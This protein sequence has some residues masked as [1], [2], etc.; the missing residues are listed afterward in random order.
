[1]DC[2]NWIKLKRLNNYDCYLACATR[3]EEQ[4]GD[5]LKT[6][7]SV[8]DHPDRPAENGPPSPAGSSG[9]QNRP[10]LG[11]RGRRAS[12]AGGNFC[13][14]CPLVSMHLVRNSERGTVH[15]GAQDRMAGRA[16][17]HDPPV[18]QQH[19]GGTEHQVQVRHG[20]LFHLLEPHQRWIWERVA[21]HEHGED[22]CHHCHAG[23]L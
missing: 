11:V 5:K 2:S 8:D 14:D 20:P 21:Q 10:L 7:F 6:L 19:A 15:A 16:G 12:A 4:I 23:W 9:S 17:Q 18:L 13:A 1:M 3:S 22:I